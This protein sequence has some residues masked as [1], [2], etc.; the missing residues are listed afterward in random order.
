MGILCLT[1]GHHIPLS[2][3]LMFI[4]QCLYV[5]TY[6]HYDTTQGYNNFISPPPQCQWEWLKGETGWRVV[7]ESWWRLSS[8]GGGGGGIMSITFQQYLVRVWKSL[9]M[10]IR[11]P[12]TFKS[13]WWHH[14]H[15]GDVMNSWY[16]RW[17]HHVLFII[18]LPHQTHPSPPRSLASL[19]HSF[20]S[21]VM[22][23]NTAAIHVVI[24]FACSAT[25]PSFAY[26]SNPAPDSSLCRAADPRLHPLHW[27][28]LPVYVRFMLIAPRL[29]PLQ[30]LLPVC[31]CFSCC[32]P[33]A[34]ASAAVCH[35]HPL[36][37]ST[38]PRLCPLW[39]LLPDPRLCPLRLPLKRSPI[40]MHQDPLVAP[41]GFQP[42]PGPM[43][44]QRPQTFLAEFEI[45]LIEVRTS[46]IT[47][48]VPPHEHPTFVTHRQAHTHTLK[49]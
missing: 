25:S 2:E 16:W 49:S 30:L 11:A 8:W 33:I 43:H 23:G 21:V 9:G 28:L 24:S 31:V 13:T 42:M 20:K 6:F 26:M 46:R 29:R 18:S 40:C 41:A 37:Y 1:W 38:A 4:P 48:L 27:L 36:Q 32:S 44:C 45:Q 17:C 39:L 35:L 5:I 14:L 12:V 15:K 10:I 7:L 3:A 22:R 47:S 34:S 19:P